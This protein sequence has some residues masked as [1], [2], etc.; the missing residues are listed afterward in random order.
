[1]GQT[2]QYPYPEQFAHLGTIDYAKYSGKLV[3]YGAG[4]IGGACAHAL[5]QRGVEFI[6]FVDRYK[7]KQGSVFFEHPVISPEE[8]YEKYKDYPVMVTCDEAAILNELFLKA[9]FKEIISCIPLLTQFIYN[10]YQ[11]NEDFESISRNLFQFLWRQA[12]SKNQK[13]GTIFL[14]ITTRCTL[15][16]KECTAYI[17]YLTKCADMEKATIFKMIKYLADAIDLIPNLNL[18]GGEPLLHPDLAEIINYALEFN[19]IRQVSIVSNGTIIPPE[20]VIKAC[21]NHRILYRISNYGSLSNKLD[22]IVEICRN[23]NIRCEITNYPYWN[24]VTLPCF[25]SDSDSV[26][27]DKAI[28]CPLCMAAYGTLLATCQFTLHTIRL[29][30]LPQYKDSYLDIDNYSST[31]EF[32]IALE[33]Y[34]QRF[35][36]G[37]WFETCRYCS[38]PQHLTP[39]IP[40]AEQT[41]DVLTFPNVIISR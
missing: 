38:G 27:R 15:K 28:N 21:Q 18:Q 36:S 16:C 6:C 20:E 24:Q 30:V 7:E 39:M 25:Y 5:K 4:K 9:G 3:L 2:F 37:Q 31:H 1:M 29:G 40:V 8:M 26:L 33:E 32:R 17:P 34:I 13:I 12:D 11:G 35:K 41:R 10:G 22:Q 23:R 14:L 19:N